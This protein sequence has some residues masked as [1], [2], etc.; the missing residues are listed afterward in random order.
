L[1]STVNKRESKKRED[2][3]MK[4][5]FIKNKNNSSNNKRRRRRRGEDE[6]GELLFVVARRHV[7]N[8]HPVF[9]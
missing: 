2:R 6:G 5:E 8:D 4:N 9:D 7:L 1:L 3:E